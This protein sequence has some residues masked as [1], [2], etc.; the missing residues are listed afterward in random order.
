MIILGLH[1]D[2]WHNT[3]A[4]IVRDDGEGPRIAYV[5]EERLD[6][7]KDSRSFPQRSVQAC[8]QELGV[9]RI[10]EI[11]LVVMDYIRGAFSW[12]SDHFKT[13]CRQDVF[14]REI[15]PERIVLA[16]HHLLHAYAAF[17]TSPFDEAA[18]LVVDGRGS[19]GE[20]QSLFMATSRG[21]ELIHRSQKI[22][23]GLLYAAVT[24][25]IGFGLLQ[26]GKTMG[27]APYGAQ[28]TDSIF[29]FGG[30]FDGIHTDYGKFCAEGSYDILVPHRPIKTFNDQARAAWEV[31][32]ECERAMLHLAHHAKTTTHARNLCLSGG[33]ALN[34]VANN[35]ILRSG[36]FEDIY[37]NPAA[38]DTGIALG[39]A[40]YGY[41]GMV[42]RPRHSF[43][44]SPFLGPS[45]GALEM[46]RAIR[47]FSGF[48]VVSANAFQAA[49]QLLANNSILGCF[50]GRSEM[51][52][53]ALGNRSI[54]MSPLVARNKDV[55]N[56]RVKHRESFRPFAPACLEEYAQDYFVIDR[57][58]PYMLLVP[59]V[60]EE[61]RSVIPAV[62][63]VDGTAR[64]QTLTR[65]RNGLFYDLVSA[66]H[67]HSG[68]PVLLNTSF[69][70]AGEPIVET[71]EDAIRCFL[72]TQ[73]DALLL[74]DV[75]LAKNS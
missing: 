36:L 60:R 24:Q 64:L 50:Q 26:E 33:V 47:K 20:T 53:R 31:Q 63:H 40:L 72:S 15:A 41:H 56:A 66:F 54:L 6:R 34:S 62:T 58:S 32:H 51:G 73:I 52:P 38:S 39:A 25:A 46:G 12:R 69:N 8:M 71:P 21:M 68:V 43:S 49:A 37:I 9:T 42:G 74:G 28:N 55:L 70:V 67:R 5:A 35:K 57:P 7:V 17:C 3:G 48:S 1:K 16:N 59:E 45:Y 4:A 75:L 13:A 2:P 30:Q 27:L 11:D 22:G 61:K 18:V 19:D 23:I 29:E 14:L 10:E 65:E 44:L